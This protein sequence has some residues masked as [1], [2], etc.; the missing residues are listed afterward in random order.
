[1]VKIRKKCQGLVGSVRKIFHENFCPKKGFFIIFEKLWSDCLAL[2]QRL[3]DQ[4]LDKFKM[5]TKTPKAKKNEI[6][7]LEHR[8]YFANMIQSGAK[9]REV[10]NEHLRIFKK[11]IS[12]STYHRIK[13]D[14]SVI[15][16]MA[17]H[18]LKTASYRRQHEDEK[19]EFES[20]CKSVILDLSVFATMKN[21]YSSWLMKT[22]VEKGS[23]NVTMEECIQS[24]AS[25]FNNLDVRVINNGFKK[26]KIRKFQNEE[27]VD[28]DISREE[29]MM[30]VIERMEKFRCHDSD[31]E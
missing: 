27:T 26:T 18:R 19:K 25:I 13:K 16:A 4:N 17:S 10:L 7:T 3:S 6:M 9:Y 20:H 31:D 21:K 29:H 28:I 12:K 14:A 24:F 8:K 30:N 2:I 1:M 11:T 23:E 5:R 22:F 15:L